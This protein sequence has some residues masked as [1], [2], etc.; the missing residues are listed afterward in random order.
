MSLIPLLV[1]AGIGVAATFY[2]QSRIEWH[3]AKANN[4][5]LLRLVLLAT[6]IGLGYAMMDRSTM[7]GAALSF[8]GWFGTV[9][10][11]AAGLLFLKGMQRAG[12][13]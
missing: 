11:P 8:L 4:V 1:W 6:G 13:S 12:K 10:V 5:V 7:V 2:A 9:H 3:I